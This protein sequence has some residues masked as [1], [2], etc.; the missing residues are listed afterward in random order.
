[1]RLWPST[2]MLFLLLL[3]C[4]PALGAFIKCYDCLNVDYH[5]LSLL[6]FVVDVAFDESNKK[7]KFLINTEVFNF[8]TYPSPE[9]VIVDVNASTNRYTTFHAEIN[10]MG[11]T[12]ID[13]NLRFC[14]MVAVKRN[15]DFEN[16]PRFTNNSTDS[17]W[18]SYLK[19]QLHELGGNSSLPLINLKRTLLEAFG[20]QESSAE[21]DINNARCIPQADLHS[22]KSGVCAKRDYYG[23]NGDWYSPHNT[24]RTMKY[25]KRDPKDYS[26]KGITSKGLFRRDSEEQPF[27]TLLSK[28]NIPL[29][30]STN[31]TISSIFDN[32]TG[33]LVQCPL[34]N[35]DLIMIYYE[36]DV[37]DHFH[38]LGSYTVRFSVI[39]NDAKGL[40]LGCNS[41]YVTPEQLAWIS[42]TV[43][44]GILILLLVTGFVNLFTVI[45][46][47]Y[48][49]LSNPLLFIASTICNGDLLRQLDATCERI[50]MYL[51]F[52]LFMG[53]L[54]LNYPGF[55]QPLL[56]QLRWCALLGFSVIHRGPQKSHSQ[57]DNVYVTFNSGGLK[58]L[59]QYSTNNQLAHDLWPNFVLCML[60]WVVI[61]CGLQQTMLV[62][63]WG[64][65]KA[66]GRRSNLVNFAKNI[67]YMMG[68]ALNVFLLLFGFPFLVL[69]LFMF[70]VA[71]QSNGKRHYFPD[72]QRLQANAF[73]LTSSYE[74]LFLPLYYLQLTNN[75]TSPAKVDLR[76][77]ADF[78][79]LLQLNATDLP[80][81]CTITTTDR[82]LQ[83]PVASI[84]IGL[85]FFALWLGLVLFFVF[86]FV[87]S[88]SRKG[89]QINPN[90]SKLY[91]SMATILAWAFSYNHYRPNKVYFVIWDYASVFLKLLVIAL[92]QEDGRS[93]VICLIVLGFIDLV[94]LFAIKP[95][96]LKLTWTTTRWILPVARFLVTVM[97]IAFVDSLHLS[98]SART[99]VA[100]AQLIV[101]LVMALAFVVQLAWCFSITVVSMIK[102]RRERLQYHKYLG[103][104]I[105]T[106]DDF[107]KQFE[108]QPTDN[109]SP[110]FVEPLVVKEPLA[111]KVYD[112]LT[113]YYETGAS[114][115]SN[116]KHDDGED[117]YYRSKSQ[118]LLLLLN[119]VDEKGTSTLIT[120]LDNTADSNDVES[121]KQ[122]QQHSIIR[123]RRNDY[124]VREGDRIYKT[125]FENDAIDPEVKALWDSRNKRIGQELLSPSTN[126]VADLNKDSFFSKI[127]ASVG[128]EKEPKETG[129]HVSRPRPLVVRKLED[130]EAGRSP[131]IPQLAMETALVGSRV[132]PR[133]DI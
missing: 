120:S 122:Q 117:Y 14:D 71:R 3:Y 46:L 74:D 38:R 83:I 17:D 128:F 63:K 18:Q 28:Q 54:G 86:R 68:Q 10:F 108:Y 78:L 23:Q 11:K 100:Y 125:Y 30:A 9:P 129:F 90:V 51:Q 1:M 114:Y 58:L 92:L 127:K 60:C 115:A 27:Y 132:D 87:I 34:Y 6:P 55:Y 36:A 95:Y 61:V 12:F 67:Y 94:A 69:T 77:R 65:D 112:Y 13:E 85:F 79:F 119:P 130:I 93:Q 37:S 96:F 123:K 41:M 35:E 4:A 56:G 109:Q 57:F 32:S 31:E 40:V 121:F 113:H 102:V 52:A 97:S 43:F 47:S 110:L 59:A 39:A 62:A 64:Y 101:H 20:G 111:D 15:S 91:T 75:S 107:N 118:K 116:F 45:C 80:K 50:V 88:I 53:G 7:L 42:D 16:S 2:T 48:Q 82:F 103:P 98:E 73:D 99:Y 66:M 131:L 33:T 76:T 29:M 22:S 81:N 106:V 133:T 25:S 49:E 72:P 26:R 24:I 89:V 124:T 44:L 105:E 8:K 5:D 84:S 21:N 104:A 126:D 19:Q 70:N